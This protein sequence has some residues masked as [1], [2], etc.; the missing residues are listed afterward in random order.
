MNTVH[1]KNKDR[2]LTLSMIHIMIMVTSLVAISY[3]IK[4]H[5]AVMFA[6]FST[7]YVYSFIYIYFLR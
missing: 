6:F 5:N 1:G 3:G 4:D 2:S 7:T